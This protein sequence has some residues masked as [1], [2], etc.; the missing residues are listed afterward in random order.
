MNKLQDAI[1]ILV[2]AK[3]EAQA[4]DISHRLLEKK[5]IACSN[6]TYPVS[7]FFWWAGKIDKA[8]E[9]LLVMKSLAVHLDAIIREVKA[10]HS[11]DVPEILALPVIGG[12]AD[13][14]KWV[15]ESVEKTS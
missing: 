15:A 6:V 8:K 13:Y 10:A 3:D 2:T 9:A 1:V 7:S 14:L 12:N 5:L 11:Y 4:Q